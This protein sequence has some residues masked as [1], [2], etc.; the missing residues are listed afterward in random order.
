MAEFEIPVLSESSH[1][2]S[3]TSFSR[4]DIVELIE[5]EHTVNDKLIIMR[6]AGA[7]GGL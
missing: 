7:L 4:S 6:T 5:G 3:E 2:S 1:Q